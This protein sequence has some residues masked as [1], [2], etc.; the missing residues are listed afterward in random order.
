MFIKKMLSSKYLKK[1]F[2]FDLVYRSPS[3]KNSFD[4]PSIKKSSF[5]FSGISSLPKTLQSANTL[6]I[7]SSSFSGRVK[8]FLSRTSVNELSIR[9]GDPLSCTLVLSKIS[10]A[11]FL[12]SYPLSISSLS[13]PSSIVVNSNS[14]VVSFPLVHSRY[15]F[16]YNF[17]QSCFSVSTQQNFDIPTI[18]F[19]FSKPLF[20]DSICL[21][22]I[23]FPLFIS[24]KTVNSFRSILR[25]IEQSG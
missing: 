25:E 24:K 20:T 4:F 13:S 8:I 1:S 21:F 2:H 11:S 12:D 23:F 5:Y 17:Y 14:S 18:S 10:T 19:Y 9:K 22:S 16:P 7:L 6:K 3:I 15:F